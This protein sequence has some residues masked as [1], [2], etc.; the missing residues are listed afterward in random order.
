LRE[1]ADLATD[2]NIIYGFEGISAQIVILA[3]VKYDRLVLSAESIDVLTTFLIKKK[4]HDLLALK[5]TK[6]KKYISN[7]P[8]MFR[9]GIVILMLYRYQIIELI[10]TFHFFRFLSDTT[11]QIRSRGH[12]LF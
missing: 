5:L 8:I 12:Y 1:N 9:D 6:N 7:L 2:R 3:I 4:T 10:S 11:N